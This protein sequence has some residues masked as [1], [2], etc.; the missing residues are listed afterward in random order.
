[1]NIFFFFILVF[2]FFVIG[3]FYFFRGVNWRVVISEGM[4]FINYFLIRLNNSIVIFVNKYMCIY[5]YNC[6]LY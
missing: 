5:K 1:M 4:L 2:W 6:E 3:I